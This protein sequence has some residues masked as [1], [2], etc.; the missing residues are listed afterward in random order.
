VGEIDLNILMA[1]SV[2]D[3][4]VDKCPH[5]AACR[6]ALSRVSKATIRKCRLLN[7]SQSVSRLSAGQRPA[8]VSV[9][10]DTFPGTA[11]TVPQS[12]TSKGSNSMLSRTSFRGS[13]GGAASPSPGNASGARNVQ[14]RLHRSHQLYQQTAPAP[15][16][17][18]AT[19]ELQFSGPQSQ[20]TD[21]VEKSSGYNPPSVNL[22]Y[23]SSTAMDTQMGTR[24]TSGGS[25]GATQS[26]SQMWSS[27]LNF[28]NFELDAQMEMFDGFFFGD[29]SG[30]EA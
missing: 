10:A 17:D 2:L 22:G 13:A 20:Q 28:D 18:A 26:P 27:D 3:D 9:V 8:G 7:A 6:D 11:Q 24:D 4:L 15:A 19:A 30:R 25:A 1:T 5:A 16:P 14:R 23:S 29:L 12:D 21:E